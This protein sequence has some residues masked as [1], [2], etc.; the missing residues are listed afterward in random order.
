MI[1]NKGLKHYQVN[2]T[3][4]MTFSLDNFLKSSEVQKLA[5][6]RSQRAPESVKTGDGS[7]VEADTFSRYDSK[8]NWF[9][10]TTL[11]FLANNFREEE[12]VDV[13]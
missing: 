13:V 12:F 2:T 7:D 6:L 1:R 4:R 5:R 3:M 9:S 8:G 10:S 11:L